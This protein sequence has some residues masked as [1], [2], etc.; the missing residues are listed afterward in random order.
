MLIIVSEMIG[1]IRRDMY[2]ASATVILLQDGHR[3][4][5]ID[6]TKEMG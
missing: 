2:T 4:R 6:F 1:E 5:T 3:K